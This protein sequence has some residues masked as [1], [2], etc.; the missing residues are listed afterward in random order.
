MVRIVEVGPRDGLQNEPQ[1][2]DLETKIK[3][4]NSLA[5]SGV[6]CIEVGS[7][8][9]PKVVPQMA[10]TDALFLN[11]RVRERRDGVKFS[12]LVPNI[13]GFERVMN[14]PENS[15]PHILAVFTASSET[16]NMR[17]INM[18]VD[19]S[20][21]VISEVVSEAKHY[22]FFVR[23]YVST[24]F[25]CPYEK[26]ISTEKTLDVC[27]RLIDC[28]VDEISV[29]DTIGRASPGDVSKLLEVLL[30]HIPPS[31]LAM[32]F[33]NTYGMAIAN[34][35]VAYDFGIRIFDSSAG[36]LGGC[37]FAP[38]ALGNVA[39]EDLVFSFENS[40]I[41][42]GVDFLKIIDSVKILPIS[43]RSNLARIKNIII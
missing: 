10:Q 37:P 34:S 6:S 40:G 42:T 19:Q 23:G 5:Q 13:R 33:H 41:K 32:H 2:I 29:G 20:I 27:Q 8:V 14:L 16:F 28:G 36:G 21:K 30:K 39:T 25:W 7:F 11:L 17:N 43:P 1:I 26:K 31:R 24:A 15:R 35:F 3:F 4:I 12:A 9:S 18:T 38:G 22:D